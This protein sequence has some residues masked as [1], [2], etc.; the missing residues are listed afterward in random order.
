MS[1]NENQ[2]KFCECYLNFK[3]IKIASEKAGY[4]RSTGYYLIKKPCIK[5]YIKKKSNK[6]IGSV[7]KEDE[8][9]IYLTKIMRGQDDDFKISIKERLKAAELLGKSY[10]IFSKSQKD[11]EVPPVI[12]Y[13]ENYI[14][15]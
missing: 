14:F 13:G 6:G 9:M 12:I 1:L 8:I 3:D 11:K 10:S 5:D 15:D 2:K 4:S 7:A